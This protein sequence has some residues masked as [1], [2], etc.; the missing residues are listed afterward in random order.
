MKSNT[1]YDE[2]IYFFYYVLKHIVS[3]NG[4]LYY[5]LELL[6]AAKGAKKWRI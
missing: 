6:A 5:R 2:S 4:N 1:F 3:L